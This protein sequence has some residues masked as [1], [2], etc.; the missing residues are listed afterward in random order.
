MAGDVAFRCDAST[1]VGVGHLFRCLVLADGVAAR[2]HE[3]T[4]LMGAE[5]DLGRE[6]VVA[7]GHRLQLL[8]AGI[9]AEQEAQVVVK[10]ALATLGWVVVDHYGR[11]ARYLEL[12]GAAGLRLLAIDDMAEHPFPVDVLLNQNANAEA[13]RYELRP[14]TIRLLGPRYALVRAPY[15]AARPPAPRVISH[16]ERVLVSLGGSDPADGTGRVV[17]A[18]GSVSRRLVVDVVVGGAFPHLASLERRA[19]VSRHQVTIRRNLRDLVDVMC[20]ADLFIGAGGGTTWEACCVGLPIVLIPIAANQMGNAL[21]LP[22]LGAALT[23]GDGPLQPAAVADLVDH[24]D[25]ARATAAGAAAWALVDG[26]GADRVL[27]AMD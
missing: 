14:R 9:A 15:R 7:A 1:A 26:E 13:I 6:R 21:A 5:A 3:A 24:L 2:G 20:M 11:D 27:E 12:I 23:K 8:P 19:A 4:V 16:V 10:A 17:E 22:V 18:L 25:G